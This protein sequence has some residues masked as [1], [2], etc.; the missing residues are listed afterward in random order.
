MW[1][2]AVTP[3]QRSTLRHNDDICYNLDRDYQPREV[4]SNTQSTGQN[5]LDPGKPN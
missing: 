3:S 1:R 4:G 5:P 2:N